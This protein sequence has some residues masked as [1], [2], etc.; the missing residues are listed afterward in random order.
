MKTLGELVTATRDLLDESTARQWSDAQLR[1]WLLDGARDVARRT[2]SLQD[3]F[4]IPA[5][6]GTQEYLLPEDTVRIHRVEYVETSSEQTHTLEYRDWHTMDEV[7][8][9]SQTSTQQTPQMWTMWG[10]PPNL[11][12][13][14]YPTPAVG[15]AFKVF[16]YRLP[17]DLLDDGT[18]DTFPIELPEGW[19]DLAVEWA[20]VQAQR[21]DAD[22]RW[23]EARG[24]YEDHLKDLYQTSIRWTDN[25]G[26]IS[27]GSGAMVPQFLWDE[28]W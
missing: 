27:S 15:G 28:G 26:M 21:R 8:W 22:P 1:R 11:K 23:Q 24:I 10:Y 3:R 25:A 17:L 13:V 6:A 19:H 2:E 16:Y 18:Q 20:I 14:V 12:L 5:T 4:S 7:W 9:L